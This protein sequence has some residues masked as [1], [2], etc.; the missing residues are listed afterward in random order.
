MK[1]VR[2]E[3]TVERRQKLAI[4]RAS[5][6]TQ[7]WCAACD[8]VAVMVSGQEAA[9]LVG[10]RSWEIYRQAE[11]GSLHSEKSSDGTLLI[12]VNSLFASVEW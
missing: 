9:T 8:Q 7:I 12:C 11:D 2:V 6:L 1:K 5:T 3:F 10:K 4:S